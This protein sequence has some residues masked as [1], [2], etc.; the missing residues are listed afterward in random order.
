MDLIVPKSAHKYLLDQRTHYK[1]ADPGPLYSGEMNALY[2]QIK[3]SLP[4]DMKT[5]LDIGS[6]L[7]GIDVVMAKNHPQSKFWLMDKNGVVMERERKIGWHESVNTF[8]PYNSFIETWKFLHENGM[9]EDRFEVINHIPDMRFDLVM[10]FLSWGFHYPV[11]TYI[12]EV[13]SRTKTLIID[14]RKETDGLETLKRYFQQIIP[15]HEG[16]KYWRVW[17]WA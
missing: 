7:G 16:Q 11:S 10:S 12:D 4:N 14:I 6:G 1:G 8:G 13:R 15:I 9:A 5:V 3:D 2:D 17:C